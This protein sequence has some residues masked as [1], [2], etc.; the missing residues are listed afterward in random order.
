M[1]R[2]LRITSGSVR[3]WRAHRIR[4]RVRH[5]GPGPERLP[6][7]RDASPHLRRPHAARRRTR[8]RRRSPESPELR[9][10][11]GRRHWS[12]FAELCVTAGARGNLVPDAWLAAVAI[13]SG[14]EWLTTDRD[15]ARFPGLRWR[16]PIGK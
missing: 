4:S 12:I 9:R 8:L 2:T 1:G 3:D 10:N 14:A 5:G 15:Y 16:H 11:P 7:G 6:Q 13:E